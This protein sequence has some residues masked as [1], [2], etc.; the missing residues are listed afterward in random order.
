LLSVSIT[1]NVV[2]TSHDNMFIVLEGLDG[3][4]KSTQIKLLAKR[5]V[6]QG[7]DVLTCRDPG[8]TNLSEELR[9]IVKFREDI[10]VAPLAEA[11]LFTAARV[12]LV[13][14][15]IAPAL[16][17]RYTVICDRFEL[18]THVYQGLGRNVSDA[19]VKALS[20][21]FH[22][23]YSIMPHITF[24]LDLSVHEALS[25]LP[26]KRDKI[27]QRGIDYFVNVRDRYLKLSAEFHCPTSQYHVIDAQGSS[28]QV[29][30]RIWTLI[31]E[32]LK[33]KGC[34]NDTCNFDTSC[35]R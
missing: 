27:E 14:E 2:S 11:L 29:H 26:E 15:I 3:C 25:R 9:N 17:K 10:Q 12:Q 1:R 18:S 7:H 21:V 24:V 4:G 20:N 33:Q 34:K 19:T 31:P 30:E 32:T 28:E 22:S 23:V 8:S 16:K 35:G 6:G 5:L 13:D